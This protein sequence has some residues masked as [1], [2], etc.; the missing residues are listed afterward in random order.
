MRKV[1]GTTRATKAQ[2]TSVVCTPGKKIELNFSS[3]NLNFRLPFSAFWDVILQNSEDYKTTY[4]IHKRQHIFKTLQ[5]NI[6][7]I[8][9]VVFFI[10]IIRYS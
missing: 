3:M 6:H 5:L 9:S 4:R 1:E 8:F 2:E 10:L 7:L